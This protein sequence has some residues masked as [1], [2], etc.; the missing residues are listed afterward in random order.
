MEC[1]DNDDIWWE[2]VLE[3]GVLERVLVVGV[4]EG[5]ARVVT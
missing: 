5:G 4:L 2:G 1:W 3:C